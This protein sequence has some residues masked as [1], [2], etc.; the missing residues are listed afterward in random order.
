MVAEL[1]LIRVVGL[2]VPF[3]ISPLSD[4]PQISIHLLEMSNSRLGMCVGDFTSTRNIIKL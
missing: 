3:T 2:I 1:V 4:H